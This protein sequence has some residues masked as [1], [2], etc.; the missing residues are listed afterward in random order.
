M[1]RVGERKKHREQN[2]GEFETLGVEL[3]CMPCSRL[4]DWGQSTG[5]GREKEKS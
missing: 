3:E 5:Q 1:G 4:I 2:T